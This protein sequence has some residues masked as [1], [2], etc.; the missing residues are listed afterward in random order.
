M[1]DTEQP[2]GGNRVNQTFQ[3]Q[4][5]IIKRLELR[6]PQAAKLAGVQ[7]PVV[8]RDYAI[9]YV[10]A[11]IAAHPALADTLVFKGGTALRKLYLPGYR[12]SEDL[13]FSAEGAPAKDDLQ[14]ALG[15]AAEATRQLLHPHGLF[16]LKVE[17]NIYKT[18]HPGAQEDFDVFVWFPWHRTTAHPSCKIKLEVTFDEPILLGAEKRS[19]IHGYEEVLPAQVSCYRIEEIVAEKMRALLQRH[20]KLVEGTRARPR[21]RDYYD[22]WRILGEFS[23]TLDREC[24]PGLL[25]RKCAH[26]GV[27]FDRLED[28]FTEQLVAEAHANW[29]RTLGTF[30]QNLPPCAEVLAGLKALIPGF[31]PK[32]A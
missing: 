11:G 1:A 8:E 4:A 19:L 29:S 30:V 27:A 20:K 13:D 22:L 24:L 9:G 25:E 23:N 6:I 2:G 18:P 26:K 28:F 15:Q 12:F 16:T 10:L 7:Q 31:F 5:R 21:A 17:R 14:A 32:L 3:A